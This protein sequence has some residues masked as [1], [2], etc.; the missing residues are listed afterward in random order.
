MA[1]QVYLLSDTCDAAAESVLVEKVKALTNVQVICGLKV[2]AVIGESK[3]SGIKYLDLNTQ[4]E[5]ELTLDGIFVEI[6][7][8]PKTGWLKG[9][10]DLNERGEIKTDK[11]GQ[12]SLAGIFAA[13]DC[14]D[15]GFKQMIISAG[16][17]A[18]A[19]LTTYKYLAAKKGQV[20]PPDWGTK[21]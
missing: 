16:E 21:K 7:F 17:G 18:K 9:V 2:S 20:A 10:V 13:G 5:K 11:A 3:V 8:S 19:A 12:T 1:S 14:T 6:G 15:V 4:E